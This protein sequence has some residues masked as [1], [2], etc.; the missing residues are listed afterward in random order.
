MSDNEEIKEE[1]PEMNLTLNPSDVAA[2]QRMLKHQYI[3]RIDDD[4]AYA[5]VDKIFSFYLGE[6]RKRTE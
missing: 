1:E 5:A 2:L 6:S 4:E 3:N